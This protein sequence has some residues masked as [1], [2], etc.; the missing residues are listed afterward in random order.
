MEFSVS[1]ASGGVRFVEGISRADSDDKA[2][3]KALEN[4]VGVR[5]VEGTSSADSYRK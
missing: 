4:C 5:F 3:A 2:A 1:L